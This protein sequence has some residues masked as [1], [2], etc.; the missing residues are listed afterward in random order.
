[1]KSFFVLFTIILFSS[2][3]LIF[4]QQDSTKKSGW[5]PSGIAGLN[6][7]QITL[8]NWAQGGDNSLTWT[9]TGDFSAQYVS[10]NLTFKNSLK[11]AYGRTKLGGEDFRTNDNEFYLVNL[12][13]KNIGWAVDPYFSNTI[14]TAITKGYDYSKNPPVEIADLFDPGYVTQSIGF[15]Y[16]KLKH[17]NTRLGLAA[18]EVFTKNN[19]KYTDDITTPKIEKFKFETGLES[20]SSTEFTVAENLLAKSSLRLFTRFENLK[21]WDVRWDNVLIAKVN[22]FIN[23]SLTFLF[24]YQEDQ[25]K[26]AQMKQTL[27]LGI[28]YTIF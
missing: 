24:V 13:S 28:V 1:M 22:D 14:R 21:V 17:F 3:N 4:T 16:E 8:N 20:V 18:Q 19:T 27:L 25:S 10:D 2:T 7:S 5:F 9:L 26:Q 23:V 11:A 6:L 15:T 12:I